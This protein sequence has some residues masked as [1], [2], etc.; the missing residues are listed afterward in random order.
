M[1]IILILFKKNGSQKTFPLPSDITVIGRRQDCDLCVPLNSVSKRHCQLNSNT[2]I[3]KIR[4]L[5]SRNG[6]Y[7]NN[8]RISEAVAKA[9]DY[10]KIGPLTFLIQIDG[11]PKKIVPPPQPAQKPAGGEQDRTAEKEKPI[12]TGRKYGESKPRNAVNED[13]F[14]EL[15]LNESDTD[16][17]ELEDL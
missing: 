16:L 1:N 15:E 5:N 9:G 10:I 14:A 3:L 17:A 8:K 13:S 6:T 2:T 4:D 7:L 12:T 11:Q